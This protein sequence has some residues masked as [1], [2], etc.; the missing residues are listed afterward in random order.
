MT[1]KIMTCKKLDMK[2]FK[3]FEG[4]LSN[5]LETRQLK[6]PAYT[7][8]AFARQLGL[9]PSRLS[10]ILKGKI[11]ISVKRAMDIADTLKLS[12]KD[13]EFFV[14][15]VQA[16]HD[17]NPL[18]RQKAQDKISDFYDKYTPLEEGK[19]SNWYHLA[20]LE[21]IGLDENLATEELASKLGLS[22]D[23]ADIS[24]GELLAMGAIIK[25]ETLPGFTIVDTNRETAMDIPSESVKQL[26]E[27]ILAKAA[28]ELR[29]QD[30]SNRDF[31][32]AVFGFNK[33]QL[34]LA[35]ERIKQ[36]RR[37]FMKEFESAPHKDSVYSMSLQF[38]ELTQ[39][40]KKEHN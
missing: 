33:E 13:K 23:M 29:L 15:L 7:I 4:Y 39:T 22:P 5:V 25:S 1:I 12:E 27:Q 16:E 40:H 34:P 26:N 28:Q 8:S 10:E 32:I 19:I 11:G 20:L 9:P 17:R 2:R 30:V 24:I 37:D 18:Q 38:F 6:N 36:F 3:T 21:L 35:K 31:S 14:H